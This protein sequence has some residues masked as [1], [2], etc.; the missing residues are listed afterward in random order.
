MLLGLVVE[1]EAFQETGGGLGANPK[2][3]QPLP[4]PP[5]WACRYFGYLLRQFAVWLSVMVP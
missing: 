4:G 3:L 2:I 1:V 5:A